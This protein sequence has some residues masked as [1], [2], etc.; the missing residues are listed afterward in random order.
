MGKMRLQKKDRF[1]KNRRK[2]VYPF[3]IN[4][5]NRITLGLYFDEAYHLN[6]NGEKDYW[7]K[8]YDCLNTLIYRVSRKTGL[9]P[10]RINSKILTIWIEVRSA[11]IAAV[12]R[13]FQ[14]YD[15][16]QHVLELSRKATQ[17]GEQKDL[18][19]YLD[20]RNNLEC[21]DVY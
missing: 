5:Y 20:A 2:Y 14:Q 4:A 9:A 12:L 11:G 7:T 15:N 6:S 18:R 13:A 1:A 17:T 16:Y 10:S 3:G 19:A 8:W 21:L